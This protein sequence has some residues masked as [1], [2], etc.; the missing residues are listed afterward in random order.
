MGRRQAPSTRS[1][2]LC[3]EKLGDPSRFDYIVVV[4]GLID[5]IERLEAELRRIARRTWRYFET[6]VGPDTHH[7][8]PDN[9]Q[10]DP[11]PKLAERTSPTNIGLYLMSVMSARDFGWIGLDTALDR[12][13]EVLEVIDPRRGE[14]WRDRDIALPTLDRLVTDQIRINTCPD[15]GLRQLKQLK[16]WRDGQW[17][18]I[19]EALFLTVAEKRAALGLPPLAEE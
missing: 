5:E 9:W 16:Y 10:A 11:E 2:P 7:L 8:P 18:R 15:A 3:D 13:D 14:D 19:G 12:I 6:F 17:K 1:Q 4:G